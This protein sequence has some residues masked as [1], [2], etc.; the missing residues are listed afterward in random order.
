VGEK[1]KPD[2]RVLYP[3]NLERKPMRDDWWDDAPR[4]ELG[5]HDGLPDKVRAGRAAG[6]S[7]DQ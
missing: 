4:R 1:S 6:Q 7:S 5:P 3:L 2:N